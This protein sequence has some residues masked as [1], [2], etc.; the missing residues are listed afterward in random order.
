MKLSQTQIGNW[1]HCRQGW[2]YRYTKGIEPKPAPYLSIGRLIH[3]G[4]EAYYKNE[5]VREYMENILTPDMAEVDIDFAFGIV[6]HYKEFAEE[7]DDF[8]EILATELQFEVPIDPEGH[9]KLTGIMDM[10]VR[11][12]DGLWIVE[13]KTTASFS[14]YTTEVLGFDRQA[15]LYLAAAMEIF[16]EPAQGVLFNVIRRALPKEPEKLKNGKLSVRKDIDTTYKVYYNSIQKN[17]DS[18]NEYEEVLNAL[19]EKGY[20]NFF[21]RFKERRTPQEL[22]NIMQTILLMAQD[23]QTGAIYRN[24]GRHCTQCG[25]AP[26]CRLEMQG[27]DPEPVLSQFI[28]K[29]ED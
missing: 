14:S 13:H 18:L 27:Y 28:I 1:L 26:I 2:F 12:P 11:R 4:L 9:Y 20:S 7:V 5:N 8:Q 23:M 25:Y 10:V 3:A 6:Q 16:N 19:R 24:Y 15:S 17:M 22:F 21:R 29:E